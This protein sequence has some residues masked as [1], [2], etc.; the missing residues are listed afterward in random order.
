M[1]AGAREYSVTLKGRRVVELSQLIRLPHKQLPETPISRGT[2]AGAGARLSFDFQ[3]TDTNL[4][5]FTV[6]RAQG[7]MMC[8]QLEREGGSARGL[9]GRSA[10]LRTAD[11]IQLRL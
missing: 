3:K 7:S 2:G 10:L 1:H 5:Q 9:Q 8:V 6:S 4:R 11:G